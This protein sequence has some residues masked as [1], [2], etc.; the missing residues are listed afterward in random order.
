MS[1]IPRF[2]FLFSCFAAL[3]SSQS[4]LSV[5]GSGYALPANS[6]TA[7]PG[8]MMNVSV[9]G[10]NLTLDGPVQGV[11]DS[12]GLPLQLKG[13][14]VDFVQ[15][16]VT[17]QLGIRGLQQ[18]SCSKASPCAVSTTLSL[19]IPYEL[20]P[21]STDAA[22]LRIKLNGTVAGQVAI[23]PVTD[24]VH[25]MNTCDQN[26]VYLSVAYAVP[27]GACVPMV[28]HASGMLVSGSAPAVPGETLVVYA[29]GLGAPNH[30][31]PP[32][33]A[34]FRRNCRWWPSHSCSTSAI[35]IQTLTL[36]PG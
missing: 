2:A 28:E 13:V 4:G 21:G 1:K 22:L 16:P 35:P 33:A 10:L 27:P 15:G 9:A 5:T 36:R 24:S 3:G 12:G 31:T 18:S 14:A 25:I 19:Q 7:A 34:R 6:I 29:Y 8:Q 23:D 20:D 30:P 32:A 17:V 26:M 11:P